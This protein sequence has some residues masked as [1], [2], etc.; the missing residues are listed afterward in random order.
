MAHV[1]PGEDQL[2][3]DSLDIGKNVQVSSL[4]TYTN[5]PPLLTAADRCFY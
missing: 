3:I 2:E 1:I 5:T 4:L